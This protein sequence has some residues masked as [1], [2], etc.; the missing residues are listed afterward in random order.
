MKCFQEVLYFF[1][2]GSDPNASEQDKSPLRMLISSGS[3]S[4]LVLLRNLPYL[5]NLTLSGSR[6][7][8]LSF[9]LSMVRN[10]MSLNIFSFL[11]GRYWKKKGFPLMNIVPKTISTSSIGDSTITAHKL[12]IK[13]KKRLKNLAYIYFPLLTLPNINTAKAPI[14]APIVLSNTSSNSAK[15]SLYNN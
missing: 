14:A 1:L 5:F 10:L 3:S 2:P 7:P 12:N 6:F 15:P 11:P 9:R 13:S 4:R 8:S